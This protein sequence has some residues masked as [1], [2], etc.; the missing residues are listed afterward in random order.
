MKYLLDTHV[1]LW[2][3][4]EDSRLSSEMRSAIGNDES[5]IYWSAATAWEVGIKVG[6]GKLR[7]GLDL[8][9]FFRS[10]AGLGFQWLPIT[11]AHCAAVSSL[12]LH[13]RDPFDR[14]L[15]AQA[16]VEALTLMTGDP[17]LHEY[18]ITCLA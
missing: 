17:L 6:L 8:D 4:T 9:A 16:Q 1:L 7:L 13:H 12:P 15:V 14:M 18:N 5:E 10:T 2:W 11:A 3:R